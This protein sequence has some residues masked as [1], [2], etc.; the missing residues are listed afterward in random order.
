D[1]GGGKQ[2]GFQASVCFGSPQREKALALESVQRGLREC[3]LGI[4]F[5]GARTDL[6]GGQV[7][8]P[9]LPILLFFG[10]WEIVHGVLLMRASVSQHAIGGHRDLC[11]CFCLALCSALRCRCQRGLKLAKLS[12]SAS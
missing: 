6:P 7:R 8:H 4:V 3:A 10:Q 12:W 1:E 9:F 5:G 2:V 11:S